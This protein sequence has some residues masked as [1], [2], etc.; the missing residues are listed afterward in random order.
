MKN[1]ITFA[2]AIIILAI[3]VLGCSW[4]NSNSRSSNTSSA[5]EHE[6]DKTLT[7]K[8]VDSAVGESKI[9]IPECDEVVEFFERELNSP[10]DNFIT[11]AAKATVLNK[12]KESFQKSLAENSSDTKEM[13]STCREFKDQLDKYKVQESGSTSN[14]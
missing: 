9:G 5:S 10:D 2:A 11:K 1:K 3:A 6:K 14:R 7:D 8:A 4:L 13:A 12:I